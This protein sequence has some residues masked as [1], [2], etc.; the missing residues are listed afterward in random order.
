MS[1]FTENRDRYLE[2]DIA[3][4]FFDAMLINSD[5]RRLNSD[6]HF[7]VDGTLLEA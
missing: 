5:T 7:T 3:A 2:R 1:T 6:E 4:A